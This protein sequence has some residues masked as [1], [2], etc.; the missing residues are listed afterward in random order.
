LAENSGDI[1]L[2]STEFFGCEPDMQQRQSRLP[3]AVA[4]LDVADATLVQERR[5]SKN[6][7]QSYLKPVRQW[8]NCIQTICLNQLITLVK[9][10][11]KIANRRPRYLV[12]GSIVHENNPYSGL[13]L[14][15]HVVARGGPTGEAG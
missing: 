14:L 3:V 1:G 11:W 7:L 10:Y 9:S 5:L 12:R 8:P 15:C 4:A 2:R 6:G 13:L